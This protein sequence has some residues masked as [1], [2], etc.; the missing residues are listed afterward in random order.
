MFDLGAEGARRQRAAGEAAVALSRGRLVRLRQQGAAKAMLPRM[1]GRWPEIVFLNTA[2]GVTGGDRL[3]M[4]V[5]L[6]DGSAVATTQTPERAYRADAGETGRIDVRLTVGAGA[7]LHWLP[8]ETILF[9]GSALH[10]ETRAELSGDA[11]LLIVDSLV[12]GRVAMG[13]RVARLRLTDR[14]EVRRDGKPELIE[15][16]RMGPED[17]VRP[18]TAGLGH[19]RAVAALHLLAPGAP[20]RL[21]R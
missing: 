11:E 14:R 19:A 17:L 9:D 13:E 16:L 4:A 2:G 1:H 21:G 5:D 15:A 20:D 10:R 18:G 3:S 6:P 7:E 12:F 8:Q